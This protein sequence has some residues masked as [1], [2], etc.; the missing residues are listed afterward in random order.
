[1]AA[2]GSSDLPAAVLFACLSN[3]I[4][5]PMA[6]GILKHL[7]GHRIFVDSIGVR[8]GEPDP[9]A[10]AVMDEIGIDISRHRAKTFDDDLVDTS[11]DLIVTFAPEAHHKA[12]ELTRTMAVDVEYW[13]THD[14]SLATGS[15]EQIMDAYRAVRDGLMKRIKDRFVLPV[16]PVV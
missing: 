9:F 2:P 8:A 3:A 13:P 6:E 4:R 12:L 1:M 15:R 7:M 5:S 10:V 11:Y 16:S 14:P